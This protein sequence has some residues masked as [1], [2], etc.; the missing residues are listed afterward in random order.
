MTNEECLLETAAQALATAQ[1]VEKLG[2]LGEKMAEIALITYQQ[3]QAN[4]LITY[5]LIGFIRLIHPEDVERL[6]S[7]LE[8]SVE[9]AAPEVSQQ[10]K[11]T[12][13]NLL[14]AEQMQHRVN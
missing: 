11:E 9:L 10:L 4:A 8:G 12:I 2:E 13:D 6:R 3:I 5:G 14:G 1:K 7:F